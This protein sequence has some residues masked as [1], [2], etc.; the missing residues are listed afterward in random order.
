MFLY[1]CYEL[2]ELALVTFGVSGCYIEGSP[3]FH[4]WIRKHKFL[5]ADWVLISWF[6]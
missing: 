1:F 5:D 6:D 3:T 2:D 4:R